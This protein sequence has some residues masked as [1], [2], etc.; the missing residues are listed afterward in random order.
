LLLA[1]AHW[2]SGRKRWAEATE[3]VRE[4]LVLHSPGDAAA[5][6]Q[7]YTLLAEARIF[8]GD[9]AAAEAELAPG[10]GLTSK[11]FRYASFAHVAARTA[12][13]LG[14]LTEALRR[15]R[16]GLAD[17][18][19]DERLITLKAALEVKLEVPKDK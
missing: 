19:A 4:A 17:N 6:A 2:W 10:L 15:I 7:S 8:E 14:D 1:K 11:S 3:L 13:E 18:P 9:Y 16:R 12:R 5:H